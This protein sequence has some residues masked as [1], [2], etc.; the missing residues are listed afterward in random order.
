MPVV[1]RNEHGRLRTGHVLD[2]HVRAELRRRECEE[3]GIQSSDQL[4]EVVLERAFDA[5]DDGHDAGRR[6]KAST[7]TPTTTST[8]MRPTTPASAMFSEG[9]CSAGVTVNATGHSTTAPES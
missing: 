5:D 4:A 1:A 9:L 8:P 7:T 6:R 3:V 2:G